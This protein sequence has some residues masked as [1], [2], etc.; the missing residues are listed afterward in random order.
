MLDAHGKIC[1]KMVLGEL[2][3]LSDKNRCRTVALSKR[4][5]PALHWLSTLTLTTR[6]PPVLAK[7]MTQRT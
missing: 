4:N 1:W 7:G 5:L 2:E 3:H 6:R